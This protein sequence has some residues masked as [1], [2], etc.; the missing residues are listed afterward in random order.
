MRHE[1]L[2]TIPEKESNKFIKSSVENFVPSPSESE[3]EYECDVPACGDFTTFSNLLF[4]ADEDFSSNSLIISS[5]KIDFL[6][7]EFVGE[8]ILLKSI[9]PGIDKADCNSEEEIRLIEKLLYDNSSP[10]P[11]KEFNSENYDAAIESFSPSPILVKDSDSLREEIDLFLTSDNSMPSSIDED[12]Y[13]SEGDILI[14]EVLLSNDSLSLLENKSFYYDI[15]SSP[16]PPAK[17]PN[18]D[19]IEPNSGILTVKVVTDIKEKDK[20]KAKTRQNQARNGK[21]EK[22]N[23]VQANVKFKPVKTGHGFGKSTK[24]Q[25]NPI[26]SRV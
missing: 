16:R 10:C 21:R 24:N 8:L 5:S 9:P 17:P 15:P 25:S 18:D 20:I 13:D 4:D 26:G 22:V 2:Y 23:Q 14:L 19:E 12:D 11:P 3:D 1:H 6:L 7:D